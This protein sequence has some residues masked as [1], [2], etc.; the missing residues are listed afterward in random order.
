MVPKLK[1]CD[2][3]NQ[4]MP[5]RN[6]KVLPLSEKVEV[7]DLTRKEKKKF[8]PEAAKIYIKKPSSKCE[9]VRKE[10]KN[11]GNFNIKTQT[12]KAMVSVQ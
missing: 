9:I 1:N 4:G 2:P 10:K 8:V 7:L 6:Y 11:C 3:G 12:G 5:Q